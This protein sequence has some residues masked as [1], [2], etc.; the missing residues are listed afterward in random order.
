[1]AQLDFLRSFRKYQ[2]AIKIIKEGKA[3]V[4]TTH[5]AVCHVC[6]A[7]FEF[8][9]DD[10]ELSANKQMVTVECPGCGIGL[11]HSRFPTDYSNIQHLYKNEPVVEEA[12]IN[13]YL[14]GQINPD[15]VDPDVK[16]YRPP[17]IVVPTAVGSPAVPGIL[18][19]N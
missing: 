16:S 2:M 4:V 15:W 11:T 7:H 1:M 12:I 6:E 8:T 13:K 17:N 18:Q 10:G 5:E 3:D 9:S 19:V 14:D